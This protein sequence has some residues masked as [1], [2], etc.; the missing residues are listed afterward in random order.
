MSDDMKVLVTLKAFYETEIERYKEREKVYI[1]LIDR[2]NKR[3]EDLQ[4]TIEGI[5]ERVK[6]RV[7]NRLT[8]LL[9]MEERNE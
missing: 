1:N 2:L 9:D 5:E 4:D 7:I 6:E 8:Y 3:H